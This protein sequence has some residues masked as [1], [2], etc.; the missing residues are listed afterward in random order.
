MPATQSLIASGA[1]TGIVAA[2]L[3]PNIWVWVWWSDW[4]DVTRSESVEGRPRCVFKRGRGSR[5]YGLRLRVIANFVTALFCVKLDLT[6]LRHI[7]LLAS[8]FG[9]VSYA[10]PTDLSL[11][12]PIIAERIAP[13]PRQTT[14]WKPPMKSKIQF[15]LT[16]IPDVDEGYIQPN[17]GIY[18]I[19]MFW[20]PVET[21]S[22]LHEL[23]QKTVC[24]FSAATAENWRDDYKDFDKADLGMELPDWPGER[25]L[26]IRRD[27]VF[28]VIKK[29][30]DL[31]KQ[32]GCDSVEPDNVGM[33]P[34]SYR[35]YVFVSC[36]GTKAC[37]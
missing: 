32:K 13:N 27:N 16:G 4:G 5:N 3:A 24:Y 1:A 33:Y 8:L 2:D 20:T 21:I 19:D 7:P 35:S 23:G 28:K 31:A 37:S 29:R 36:F 9:A 12:E 11:S 15:I 34:F 25:Y 6:M 18:E 26:D 10:A 17:A 30:I 22:K 14:Y